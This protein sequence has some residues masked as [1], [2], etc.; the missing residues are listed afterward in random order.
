MVFLPF[1]RFNNI[2]LS[3]EKLRHKQ[4]ARNQTACSLIGRG[5]NGCSLSDLQSE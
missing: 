2:P 4:N 1:T 5:L 3:Q